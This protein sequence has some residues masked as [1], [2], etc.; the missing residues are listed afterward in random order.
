MISFSRALEQYPL[1][2]HAP[3]TIFG[4]LGAITGDR[5]EHVQ[6]GLTIAPA[7][8]TGTLLVCVELA[9]DP[10]AT[11]PSDVQ[12]SALLRFL[13]EYAALDQFRIALSA[14]L[15]NG[16]EAILRGTGT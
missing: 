13:T 16:D 14:M 8:V 10:P 5:P 1:P 15:N 11:R 9:S 2:P 3:V 6:V 7:G 4:G 12:Q